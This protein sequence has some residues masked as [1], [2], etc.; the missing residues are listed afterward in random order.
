MSDQYELP[1]GGDPELEDILRCLAQAIKLGINAHV[2]ASVVAYDPATQTA[3]VLV[4][5]RTVVRVR[6]PEEMPPGATPLPAPHLGKAILPPT[7]LTL[8][9]VIFPGTPTAYITFPVLPGATGSLHVHDRSLETW[10]TYGGPQDPVLS[11]THALENSE[12]HL[13]LHPRFSAI[14]PPTDLAATVVEGPLVKLGRAAALGAARMTDPISASS[15]FGT[16]ATA[17]DTALGALGAAPPTPFATVAGLPA[18]LGTIATGSVK[19]S[20]E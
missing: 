14:S 19:V 20:V 6:N 9:P 13:G 11:W 15:A 16:W 17:V 18:G 8:I 5:F 4:G 1:I 2:P 3:S 12:F 7:Q 10:L